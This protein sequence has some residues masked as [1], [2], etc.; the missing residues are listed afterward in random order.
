MR[1]GIF[2]D[3]W[4]TDRTSREAEVIVPPGCVAIP[5]TGVGLGIPTGNIRHREIDED[6]VGSEARRLGNGVPPPYHG[7]Y[8]LR[9]G[10]PVDREKTVKDSEKVRVVVHQERGQRHGRALS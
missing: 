9:P 6:D 8:D 7:A 5:L 2:S 1:A 3:F 4:E 10:L